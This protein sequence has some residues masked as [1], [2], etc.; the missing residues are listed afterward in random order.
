MY[1]DVLRIYSDIEKR[2]KARN[3]YSSKALNAI[4]FATYYRLVGTA[5]PLTDRISFPCDLNRFLMSLLEPGN[6]FR[7][8]S[9]PL[10]RTAFKW[11]AH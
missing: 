5:Q 3:A 10:Q 7:A 8:R 11:K 9:W 1:G 4:I 2:L 6:S